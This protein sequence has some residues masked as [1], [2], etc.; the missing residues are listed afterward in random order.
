MPLIEVRNIKLY[1]EQHGEGEDLILLCGFGR[2]LLFWAELLPKLAQNY[3]VTLFDPRGAGRSDAPPPPYSI[4]ELAQ[5]ANALMEALSIP[6]A[7]MVGHSMGSATVQSLCIQFP[8]KV[9]KAVLINSFP[10]LVPTTA[11]QLLTTAKLL[12]AEVNIEL[13]IET[14]IPWIFSRTYLNTP[15]RCQEAVSHFF[16]D[17]YPQGPA[18]FAGQQEALLRFDSTPDLQKISTPTLILGSDQDLYTPPEQSHFLHE[19]IAGSTL[20]IIRG[21]GH[22]IPIEQ[23]ERALSLI[24]TFCR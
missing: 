19:H 21:V 15:E 7:Y 23:P 6:Y 10:N 5:D 4:E 22:L 12:Q 2:N 8:A 13:V 17:P 18:G 11:F 24:Q 20:E 9:K 16:S 1:Y 3:R 14:I